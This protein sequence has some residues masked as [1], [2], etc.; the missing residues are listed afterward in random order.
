M[1]RVINTW[2]DPYDEGFSTCRKKQIE[3]HPGLT[4]LVG[5]NGAGKT[6][7]LHNIKSELKEENI[8]VISYDNMREGGTNA[9]SKSLFE[10]DFETAVAMRCSSEGERINIGLN[11]VAHKI[12]KFVATGKVYDRYASL[13]A[14]ISGEKEKEITSNERW[15][16]LDAVDS[17]L[18]IDNVIDLKKF[19]DLV[20]EDSEQQDRE[21]YIVI[22]ANE[23]ELASD[24][25]CFDVMAG[26]Y[27]TFTNY[28]EYKKFILR[29][30]E[31]K[32]KRYK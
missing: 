11:D 26:K 17:G 25:D 12:G 8:P 10:N 22:S 29:S 7:L 14:A 31:K 19:F 23:Y 3:I 2:R 4:V 20:L 13:A 9:M 5:C 18:S 1:S 24:T 6:T 27:V 15:I 30:R 21:V 28:E 32:E 16:L